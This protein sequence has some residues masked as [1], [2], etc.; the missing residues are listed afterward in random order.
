MDLNQDSYIDYREFL[1]G[2]LRI[3]C[4]TY[5]QK[6]KFV[7]EIYDFN[8]DG[9]VTKD[10]IST[11]LGYMPGVKTSNLPGEGKFTQEGGGMQN[12]KDRIE[13]MQD[14]YKI[15]DLCFGDKDKINFKEF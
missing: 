14:V 10:D 5:D 12:F 13:S 8:N 11:I 9:F 15:L 4:S 3:Y 6:T 1:S 2:L 7:F